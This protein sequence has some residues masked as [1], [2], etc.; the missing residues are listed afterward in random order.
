M[1]VSAN[2]NTF[3]YNLRIPDEKN[4]IISLRFN[5]ICEKLNKDYW[6][7]NSTYGG[8][9]VGNF[10]RQ[11]ANVWANDIE[12]IFEMPSAVRDKYDNYG[13]KG[14]SAFLNNIKRSIAEIYPN[15][16]IDATGRSIE[17]NFSDKLCFYIQPVFRNK[18]ESYTYANTIN[19]K[20]EIIDPIAQIKTMNFGNAITNNNLARLCTMVHA[21][22]RHCKVSI[23]D[24]LLDTFVYN[25]LI[26]WD[27]KD[28]SYS[29]YDIMCRDFFKYLKDL[30]ASQTVWSVIASNQKI[31]NPDNFRYK[32]IIAYH[33]AESA[34]NLEQNNKCW[35]ARQKWREVFGSKFP[36]SIALDSQLRK[37]LDKIIL[38]RK[39]QIR[40][41]NILIKKSYVAKAFQICLGLIMV[42]GVM[43]IGYTNEL[44]TGL[45]VFGISSML[46]LV[47]LYIQ[48]SNLGSV[49]RKHKQSA[50]QLSDIREQYDELLDDLNNSNVDISVLQTRKDKLQNSLFN[51]YKGTSL[52][53]SK[54]YLEAVKALN[55]S[56]EI[57]E[58]VS[59]SAASKLN[60]PVWQGNKFYMEKDVPNLMNFKN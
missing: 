54:G 46:F 52:F 28:E 27:R 9:Y 30:D 31:S 16:K 21:W 40:C 44:N 10:G 18:D 3:C 50:L 11:T 48:K 58:K 49:I 20:W 24:I 39:T 12:M 35:L 33:K 14:Q 37:Q 55:K 8:I 59:G 5:S 43:T 15:A 4:A 51:L 53:I 38:M 26:Q 57:K 42:M 25:F 17:I 56:I 29:C 2:F 23:K 19:R 47:N 60:L 1:S 32:A 22:K 13:K 34:I 45:I 6:N 36:E 7:L 41:A